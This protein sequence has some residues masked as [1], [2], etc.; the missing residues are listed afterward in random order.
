MILETGIALGINRPLLLLTDQDV[1]VPFDLQSLRRVTTKLNEKR[2]IAGVLAEYLSD[3]T[4][5]V[6][7]RKPKPAESSRR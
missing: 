6:R 4:T 1:S 5:G 3:L 2:A 7:P